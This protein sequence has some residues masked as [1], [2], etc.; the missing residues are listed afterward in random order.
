MLEWL[1]VV[2]SISCSSLS[3]YWQ[4][5]AALLFADQ[6]ELSTVSKL[7]SKPL[8]LGIMFLALGAVFWL[9]VLS[10]WDVSV[11]Y[12]LLS[13]NFVIML[14]ISK[15]AFNEPVSR[16][17]WCGVTLIMLGVAILGGASQW[18]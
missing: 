3:Q 9:G 12:P 11:A 7:L 8:L 5:R 13:S 4:K 1:L 10:Q 6:P 18:L 17:Q 15:F 14:L 2:V 16:R